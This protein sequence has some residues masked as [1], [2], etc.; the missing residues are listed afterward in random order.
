MKAGTTGTKRIL[1]NL[2]KNNVSKGNTVII[3]EK[4][5]YRQGEIMIDVVGNFCLGIE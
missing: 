5:N 1:N 2:F 4:K 3:L